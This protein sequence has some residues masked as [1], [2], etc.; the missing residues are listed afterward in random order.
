MTT[1]RLGKVF[2]DLEQGLFDFYNRKYIQNV[3]RL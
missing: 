2:T 1:T 3:L